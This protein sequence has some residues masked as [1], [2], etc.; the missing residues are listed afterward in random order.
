LFAKRAAGENPLQGFPLLGKAFDTCAHPVGPLYRRK[1]PRPRLAAT[2]ALALSCAAFGGLAS[3]ASASADGSVTG[4][5]GQLAAKA[6]QPLAET[7]H[8]VAGA[9]PAPATP[10]PA[11]GE[12]AETAAAAPQA[13]V[14]NVAAVAAKIDGERSATPAAEPSAV[15]TLERVA[16][17][18]S[19]D[20]LHTTA[21]PIVAAPVLGRVTR[22]VERA[23]GIHPRLIR[24]ARGLVSA[25]AKTVSAGASRV[26]HVLLHAAQSS[27]R[28]RSP[29]LGEAA[30]LVHRQPGALLAPA[31]SVHA[32]IL[33]ARP[34]TASSLVS[35]LLGSVTGAR[36]VRAS[37]VQ[38]EFEESDPAT[39]A[40]S[41]S[42]VEAT[43]GNAASLVASERAPRSSALDSPS[44]VHAP[45]S[46]ATPLA[47]SPGGGL[48]PVAA[49]GGGAGSSGALLLALS[50]LLLA[51]CRP[52]L[53][54]LRPACESLRAA[55][56]LLIPERPG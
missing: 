44:P 40:T 27:S 55:Q 33:Q 11:A 2:T 25:P 43:R 26:A 18:P 32:T 50:A 45:V 24:T 36:V 20:A 13:T 5:L 54:R 51:A 31:A 19:S 7:T 17:G 14:A 34:V 48:L 38:P 16:S 28:S 49:G 9:L 8:T 41:P 10:V 35:P 30:T 53:R 12:V 15:R 56:F 1:I 52:A 3:A 42:A 47:P 37:L 21:G 39:P 46:P 23:A 29:Q 4:A 6:P 22:T